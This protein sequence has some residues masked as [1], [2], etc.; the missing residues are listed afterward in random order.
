MDEQFIRAI[1]IR[2]D[3]IDSDSYI[4]DIPALVDMED[5]IFSMPITFFVGEN[6]SGK[7]S[8]DGAGTLQTKWFIHPR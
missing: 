4:R 8:G 1:S 7:L 2:W 5:M 6:G 3:K